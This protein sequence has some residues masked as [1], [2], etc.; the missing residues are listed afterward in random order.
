MFSMRAAI[1]SSLISCMAI[2]SGCQNAPAILPSFTLNV[3]C[4]TAEIEKTFKTPSP[5]RV[6][7]AEVFTFDE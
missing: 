2:S 4:P 3:T 7:V 5:G 6:V 1:I